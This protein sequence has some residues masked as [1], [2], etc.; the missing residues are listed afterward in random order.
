MKKNL[1]IFDLDGVLID[2]KQNMK[3]SWEYVQKKFSLNQN[4]NMYF[5]YIG[6]PFKKILKDLKIKNNEDAIYKN[7][8][9]FS[10]KNEKKIKLY[11]GVKTTLSKLKK[12]NF[13]AIVTSKNRQRAIS[14][15][16]HHNLKL[17]YICS[18]N[19]LLR[20]KPFPDQI[21]FVLK[22]FKM[23]KENSVYVGDT[24]I[25]YLSAKRAKIQFIF[26][27]YGYGNL[28]FQND[29]FKIRFISKILKYKFNEKN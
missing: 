20:G 10:L 12:N 3:L 15:L 14:I 23:P 11:K 21:N 5:S 9:F 1:Y 13:I 2:S 6:K 28:P 27:D 4:F 8:N 26:A 18:P 16:K 25:D 17:D 22:K 19:S 24:K 29:V 7:Y